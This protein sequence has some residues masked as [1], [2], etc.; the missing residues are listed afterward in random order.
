MSFLV[1]TFELFVKIVLSFCTDEG[2]ALEEGGAEEKG[3]GQAAGAS[4]QF[5]TGH[6]HHYAQDSVHVSSIADPNFSIPDPGSRVKQI[7][8]SRIRIK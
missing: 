1:T 3:G 4:H 7:T 5:K 8:G 6:H 2:G